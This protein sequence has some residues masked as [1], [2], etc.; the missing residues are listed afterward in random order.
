[1]KLK[2]SKEQKIGAFAVITLFSVYIL[3]NYLKG[4][5]IFT[6]RNTYYAIYHDVEGLT[7]TGPVYIRGLKVGTVE[8][9]SY[10]QHKDNFTVKLKVKRD[11]VLPNNSVAQIYNSDL[12]GTKS[13]RINI[14]DGYIHLSSND[15]IKTSTEITLVQMVTGELMPFKD[16]IYDLLNSLE[17]T[18]NNVNSLLDDNNKENINKSLLHLSKTLQNL[19]KTTTTL[20]SSAPEIASIISNINSITLQLDSNIHNINRGIS[21]FADLSDSLK[22]ADINGTIGAL[23]DLLIQ[24]RNPEGSIGKLLETDQLHN[25]IEKL[26]SD[27]DTLVSN[28]NKNPRKYIRISVF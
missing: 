28:I 20:N 16:K 8:A 4:K 22:V 15:T 12:L 19:D 11:Y 26:I 9:I 13:I 27:I 6:G 10:N 1:M 2:L 25:S 23:K 21:N 7:V 18:L 5:D 24:V 17:I 3:I 14:G